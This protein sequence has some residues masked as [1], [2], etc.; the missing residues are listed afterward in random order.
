[1]RLPDITQFPLW[2][3]LTL[4]L[5]LRILWALIFPVDPVSDA[6]AY[7]IFATNIAEHGVYGFT[8]ERPGAYWAVG[9]AAIY[10]F[11]YILLGTG[12]ELS[13]VLVNL[14]SSAIVI[15]ALSD[16][17][18]RWF[19]PAAGRWAAL[20]FAVWPL[21]IQFTT[22]LAS[23]VHFMAVCLLALI[24]WE[25]STVNASGL[26]FLLLA[27]LFFGAAT[28]V[29]PIALL[30]PTSL[31][32]AAFLRGPR[33]AL[34]TLVKAAVTT[35]MIFALVAPWSAR[36][37]RVFG[38]PV[39]MST[40]FWAN[41][42]MGNHPGTDGQYTSLPPETQ[43]MGEIERAAHMKT[44]ALQDLQAMPLAIVWRTV[45]KA[46]RLHE[47]ETIG[48]AWNERALTNLIG[49][50]GTNLMKAASTGF[51]YL[52]LAGAFFGITTLAMRDLGWAVI[53]SPAVWLWLYFT[54]VHAVIVIG[55]RYHMPAIPM[56]ALLAGVALSRARR[57]AIRP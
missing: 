48:V 30:M 32:I 33:T 12:S 23:E 19:T 36:N 5:G 55:D 10:A 53:V 28:Y 27:G 24:A 54:G 31:A 34:P 2:G 52:A 14:V 7:N 15:W 20:L 39:F 13:V 40:N 47:R 29:R 35:A 25:R 4:G 50:T 41:F 18:T 43:T 44:I 37:E 45:W 49:A 6:Q 3:I 22:V 11:G 1:M 51:W 8:P 56:V 26:V 9:T 16:L 38:D 57:Q 42:W 21:A 46:M 17:G